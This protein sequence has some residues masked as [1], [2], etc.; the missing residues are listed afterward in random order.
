[1]STALACVGWGAAALLALV[2]LRLRRRL[3]L[4]AQACHELRGPAPAIG[5]AAAALR[6]APGGLRRA[7][8]FETQLD[9]LGAGLEDLE[10][11]REGRRACAR[12]VPMSIDRLL[13]ASAAG[14]R[15][16]AQ[17]DGRAL[18]IRSGSGRAVVRADRGR[19][20]QALGNLLANALEHGSGTVEL[21]GSQRG[22]RVILEVRD[23]GACN[24]SG[25]ARSGRDPARGRGLGI[26]AA[27]V[28]EAGGKLTL[29]Q[30]DGGTVAAVELPVAAGEARVAAV[31]LPLADG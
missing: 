18:R 14:W 8:P 20:C 19:L 3:E 24:R 13:R 23:G 17:A 9:R 16:A 22:D 7:L 1:M 25:T 30:E 28:E 31:D 26:A 27:A 6:R 12:P 2:V 21:S 10:A 4:A 29:V 15:P 5:L 11:A